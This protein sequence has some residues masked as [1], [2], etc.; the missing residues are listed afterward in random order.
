MPLH[1]LSIDPRH[2]GTVEREV[3]RLVALGELDVETL[4]DPQEFVDA[5]LPTVMLD[6]EG[7]EFCVIEEQ[8]G[9]REHESVRLIR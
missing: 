2:A 7:N 5:Q 8:V 4:E 3:E 6:P 1:T 9:A